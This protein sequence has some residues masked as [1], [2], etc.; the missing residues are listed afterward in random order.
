MTLAASLA[1]S[2][3]LVEIVSRGYGGGPDFLVGTDGPARFGDA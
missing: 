1:G 3:S 2:G